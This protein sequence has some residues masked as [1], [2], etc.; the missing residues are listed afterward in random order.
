MN[1][2]FLARDDASLPEGLWEEIDKTIEKSASAQM[3]SRRF[4]PLFGPLGPGAETVMINKPDE[5]EVLEDGI[6]TMEGQEIIR[7]P[8]LFQDFQLFWRNLEY[9]SLHHYP[10][11]L[12]SATAA[13]QK[14]ASAEDRLVFFGNERLGA[15]GLFNADGIQKAARSDWKTGEGAFSDIASGIISF[16]KEGILGEK[17]LIVSPDLYVDLQR[18]Q[19]SLG[20]VEIDRINSLLGHKV[21]NAPVLGP[22][23]AILVCAEPQ[24][25]DLAIGIDV[26][27]G[28]LELADFNHVFRIMETAA[29]RL[30]NPKAVVVFE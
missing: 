21:I 29:L 3:T 26:S 23:K 11:D 6:G 8:Q 17:Y 16:T 15:K 25:M 7:L 14:L 10:V 22:G 1:K 19:P 13:A 30:K 28:Y 2:E 20:M 18:I 24:Y 27:T 5:E 12:S 9:S 4:L